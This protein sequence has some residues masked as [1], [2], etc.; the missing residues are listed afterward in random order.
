MAVSVVDAS[1]PEPHLGCDAESFCVENTND[2]GEGSLRQAITDANTSDGPDVVQFANGLTGTIR[3]DGELSI[4][5]DVTIDGPNSHRVSISGNNASRV[6]GISGAET[7]VAIDDL[8]IMNGRA[9][10]FGGGILH[11]GGELDV[12]DVVFSRNHVHGVNE[13]GG[14]GGAIVA[15]LSTAVTQANMAV[16]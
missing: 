12:T 3:L 2:S 9:D 14:L 11:M 6:F 7:D 8:T 10:S 5:D 15:P 4:T 1:P 13:G 16:S